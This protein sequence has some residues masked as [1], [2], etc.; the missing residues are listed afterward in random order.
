MAQITVKL[1]DILH[2]H[3]PEHESMKCLGTATKGNKKK[4]E[5]VQCKLPLGQDRIKRVHVI[6]QH[7]MTFLNKEHDL[8]ENNIQELVDL[9]FRCEN[10]VGVREQKQEHVEKWRNLWHAQLKEH[11]DMRRTE[12]NQITLN[13][14]DQYVSEPQIDLPEIQNEIHEIAHIPAIIQYPAL[15]LESSPEPTE[16]HS[17]PRSIQDDKN[18]NNIQH[19]SNDAV[20]LLPE[21]A[22]SE[23]LSDGLQLK[24]GQALLSTDNHAPSVFISANQRLIIEHIISTILN[25]VAIFQIKCATI[26]CRD[27]AGNPQ[28][29]SVIQFKMLLGARFSLP[30]FQDYAN[31]I[32]PIFVISYLMFVVLGPYLSFTLVSL[33][34]L[35]YWCWSGPRQ[36]NLIS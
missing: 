25:W 9:L 26:L 35:G 2:I 4:V 10:H 18:T 15:R 31:F 1:G 27:G 17:T 36:K 3:I 23:V 22:P 5:A 30:S 20:D 12:E 19:S 7:N 14:F 33:V 28:R 11:H 16:I 6:L 24:P 29:Q 32:I 8:I 34:S 13:L 21:S